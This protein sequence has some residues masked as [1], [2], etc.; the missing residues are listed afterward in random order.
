[1]PYIPDESDWSPGVRSHPW[2]SPTT[3][4][5]YRSQ[6]PEQ[7]TPLDRAVRLRQSPEV[8][9]PR[10]RPPPPPTGA[11]LLYVFT[12]VEDLDLDWSAVTAAGR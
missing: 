12:Q 7:L 11:L 3:P 5:G 4:A 10:P 6:Q 8:A 2:S 9:R 1:M